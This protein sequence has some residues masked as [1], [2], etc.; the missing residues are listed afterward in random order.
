MNEFQKIIDSYSSDLSL[1][2]SISSSE[3]EKR[4]GRFLEAMAKITDLRHV[5]SESKIKFTTVQAAVYSEA[6]SKGTA[7]TMTENKVTAEA[8]AEYSGAREDLERIE[9]DLAYLKAYWDIF[10]AAHVF[11][12][13]IAKGEQF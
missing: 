12:R 5:F 7:K 4:A 13:Q 3:A 6:L 9:N 11:Y 10:M 1:N 2:K 8:S